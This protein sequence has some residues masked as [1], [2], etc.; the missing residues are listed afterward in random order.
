MPLKDELADHKEKLDEVHG[1]ITGGHEPQKGLVFQM[2]IMQREIQQI[3]SYMRVERR[4][5]F[6]LMG[7]LIFSTSDKFVFLT[8]IFK[9]LV[10]GMVGYGAE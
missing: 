3:L 8:E 9:K 10:I 5:L 4:V 2:V 1:Y 6:A 7:V